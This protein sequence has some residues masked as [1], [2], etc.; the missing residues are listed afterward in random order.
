VLY[1]DK[2]HGPPL[3][4]AESYRRVASRRYVAVA[5]DRRRPSA[6]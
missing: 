3:A 6:R 2:E 4:M 1:D 5:A